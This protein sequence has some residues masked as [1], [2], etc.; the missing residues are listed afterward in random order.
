MRNLLQDFRFAARQM[1]RKPG[2]AVPALLILALGIGAATAIFSVLNPILLEPLPYPQAR[3]ILMVWDTYQGKRSDL[4]FH[5]FREVSE[6]SRSV[7]FLAALK[8]WQPTVT[9]PA[10]PERLDGQSV[11]GDY[12]RVLGIPPAFGRNFTDA[13]LQPQAPKVVVLSDALWRRLYNSDPSIVGR[14]IKLNDELYTVIGVMPRDFENALSRSAELWSPLR[15]DPAHI[16]DFESREWG[17]HLHMIARMRPGITAVQVTTEL[18]SIAHSPVSEFPRPVWASLNNGFIVD[19]LQAEITRS[20]RPALFAVVVAVALLL[21]IACVNVANLLLA[22]AIQRQGEFAMRAALG[23]EQ[24]RLIQQLVTETLLVAFLAAALGTAIAQVGLRALLALRPADLPRLDAIRIDPVVL[25]FAT[26]VAA[27]IG[28]TLGIA[29]A[30][31]VSRGQLHLKIQGTSQLT[32]GRD[33][34]RRTLVVVEFAIALV[35]LVSAGLL[36]HSLQCIFA[37]D[38]GYNSSQLLTMQV[39]TSGRRLG[40]DISKLQFFEQ[41]LEA[42]RHVP[43]VESASLTS[44]LPMSGDLY[45]V[46]GAHFE[47]SQG[48]S[49]Y[50]YLVTPD[51]FQTMGIRLLSGR[52][53]N[54]H[55]TSG[56][57]PVVLISESLAKRQ[58]AGRDP[59]GAHVHVGP[60]DRPW[61]T[62]V[63]VV[64][65]VKQMS[66]ADSQTDAVY[67]TPAQSW[68]QESAM[69]LV[70]RT[71]G[72]AASLAPQVRSAIWSVDKDQPITKVAT[73]SELL[74]RSEAQRRFAFT[75][76]QVFALVAMLLA[77]GGI[78][79]MVSAIVSERTREIGIRSALGAA[80]AN[81]LALV[82]RQGMRLSVLGVVI[83]LVGALLASRSLVSLLYGVSRLDPLTYFGTAVL[84]LAVSGIATW[85]PAR[86]ASRI[87]PSVTLRSE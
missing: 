5:T 19:A 14:E 30:F 2:F 62:V 78:Y 58:F 35:L 79:G 12:F 45:Q 8:D 40:D 4:T 80:P 57:Q 73:M 69:S 63:G 47:G 16:T 39:Q 53:L 60:T 9:G 18:N 33:W 28:L 50:R 82:L 32:S 61:Y 74:A 86:R 85:I 67:L 26:A 25:A 10:E 87:D 36:L 15:Y 49:V 27:L 38:P 41:A 65:D 77:A 24:K 84:L 51:Y 72:G 70:V 43:G 6:R 48:Q 7:K 31:H 21:L 23:A 54:D 46:Y 3:R 71:R 81:I 64:S 83:G 17:H 13:D 34:L 29:T 42:A 1:R 66:L 11:T 22:R 68:S 76:F 56:A 20:I 59:L 55:D 75:V 37:V 44:L 52:P